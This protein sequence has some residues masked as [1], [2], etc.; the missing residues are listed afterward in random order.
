MYKNRATLAPVVE[1]EAEMESC[2]HHGHGCSPKGTPLYKCAGY[3]ECSFAC[4]HYVCANHVHMT[5]YGALCEQCDPA[6]PVFAMPKAVKHIHH[7]GMQQ[8]GTGA[9]RVASNR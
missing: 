6:P 4:E 3:F 9:S 5:R 7:L 2:M 8:T 1:K